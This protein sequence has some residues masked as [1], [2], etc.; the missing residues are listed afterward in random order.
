MT[1]RGI[2][3]D[4]DG[5]IVDTED[6]EYHSW[7][8]IYHRYGA[9]ITFLEWSAC[10]GTSQ[11]AFDAVKELEKKTGIQFANHEIIWREQAELSLRRAMQQPA[12]PGVIDILVRADQ[13]G[14]GLAVASSSERAWVMGHLDRLN[15]TRHFSAIF[16]KDEITPV[17]PDPGLYLAAVRHLGLASEEALAFEDSPNG[18]LAAKAAG[19]ICVAVP[20]PLTRQLDLSRADMSLSSLAELPLDAILE[21]ANQLLE[22]NQ[23]F[24]ARS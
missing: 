23:R 1:I 6:P 19:M 18:I 10:L 4:F 3:F 7:V 17:K 22:V 12:L 16:T 9:D 20:N 15:L 8:E 14:I 11:D 24:A 2:V 5:I 21:R 13:L